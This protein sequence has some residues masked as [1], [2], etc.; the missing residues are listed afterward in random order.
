[1]L[2]ED[3]SLHGAGITA[4]ERNG[5]DIVLHV[6]HVQVPRADGT[7]LVP[8]DDD[9]EMATGTVTIAGVRA[10]LLNDEPVADF[11][12]ASDSCE[13]IHLEWRGPGRAEAFIIWH[14]HGPLKA[15]IYSHYQFE[16]D[17]LR[18]TQTGLMLPEA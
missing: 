4:V 17:D 15:Q 12:M 18:W 1:M 16:C 13:I 7:P 6:E 11:R 3:I 14:V 5:R 8:A 10:I 9:M 2:P